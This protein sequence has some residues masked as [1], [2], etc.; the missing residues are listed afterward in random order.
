M[1]TSDR[2][3]Y[4]YV[5]VGAGSAG[6]TLAGRLSEDPSVRVLLLEAGT[7]KEPLLS[8]IPAGFSK[9]F[10]SRHDW[11]YETEPEP[12]LRRAAPLLAAR[13][14]ARR[15]E[16][17]ER[18]DLHPRQLRSTTTAGRLRA[19]DGWTLRRSLAVFLQS[20]R[21]GAR[22]DGRARRG[23]TAPRRRSSHREPHVPRVRGG[24]PASS[25]YRR[26]TTSTAARQDGAGLYQVTQRG[27]RRWSAAN[28]YLFPA[29]RR[30]NLVVLRGVL[31]DARD[32]RKGR[33]PAPSNTSKGAAKDGD[34]APRNRRRRRAPSVR[35]NFPVVGHRPGGRALAARDRCR[36]A[37]STAWAQNLQDHPVSGVLFDCKLP[38]SLI[39]GKA[40]PAFLEYFARRTGPL[41]SNV[42][43]AGAFVRSAPSLPAPDIQFH[44]GPA[45]YHVDHGFVRP[46]GH[47]FTL[48][49]TLVTPSSR[50]RVMI[51]SS[52]P[53]A[54][55][56]IYGNVL[57]QPAD[58]KA[59]V[60]G[61]KLARDI[62]RRARSIPIAEP[63][64]CPA[65]QRRPTPS[66]KR[67]CAPKSSCSIT[68]APPARWAKT[69]SPSSTPSFASAASPASRRRR[70]DHADRDSRQHQRA[71]DHDRRTLRRVHESSACAE[72]SAQRSATVVKSA[73]RDSRPRVVV[74]ARATRSVSARRMASRLTL[75]CRRR[76][77][78]DHARTISLAT[79][80]DVRRRLNASTLAS[81]HCRA[82]LAVS[83]STQSAARTPAH[84]VGGHRNAGA[85]VA[86]DDTLIGLA[87]RDRLARSRSP[88]VPHGAGAPGFA[89]T[90]VTSCPSARSSALDDV[91]NRVVLVGS[92]AKRMELAVAR[93]APFPDVAPPERKI[94]PPIRSTIPRRAA[95]RRGRRATSASRSWHAVTP[96]PQYA[97]TGVF[98]SAPSAA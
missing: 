86:A 20:R 16:R 90:S 55:P 15:F 88:P 53:A 5:I 97:T 67:T 14:D 79:V 44:F 28:A 37:S 29:L 73:L 42:A 31:G 22:C 95:R 8:R 1:S 40:W 2:A 27:G 52:D 35:R 24:V 25:A 26:T 33:A 78:R 58:V 77:S 34:C 70:F 66:S 85:R 9:L 91:E 64:S 84:L 96:E 82:P 7:A 76:P 56:R 54:P 50:G 51:R 30:A 98:A 89:P 94:A 4:D 36:R 32:H 23:R 75:R 19:R 63:S 13:Q 57:S 6:C 72:D 62:A 38:I 49:P 65:K 12:E 3:E 71:D 83:A 45:F 59:L 61:L 43:E 68:R 92:D 39:K 11:A 21:S 17:D 47:G 48:G 18:H 69:S 87:A 46:P 60:A 80:G 41:T 93:Q 74:L 10:R 81:F